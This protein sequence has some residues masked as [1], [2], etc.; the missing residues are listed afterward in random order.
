MTSGSKQRILPFLKATSATGPFQFVLSVEL[1]EHLL[2]AVSIV[3][4]GQESNS[5]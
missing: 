3:E 4:G 1:K 2:E 5:E